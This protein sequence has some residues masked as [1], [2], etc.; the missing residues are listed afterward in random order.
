[1][2]HLIYVWPHL[3]SILHQKKNTK[4]PDAYAW[5]VVVKAKDEDGLRRLHNIFFASGS[6]D[7]WFD[8]HRSSQNSKETRELLFNA[9]GMP[10]YEEIT[11][12]FEECVLIKPDVVSRPEYKV[13]LF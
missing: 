2:K 13:Y 5:E 4:D 1:L 11:R 6:G 8:Y 10:L 7:M 12:D 9:T 3:A